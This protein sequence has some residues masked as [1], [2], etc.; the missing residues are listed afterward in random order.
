MKRPRVLLVDEAPGTHRS[1]AALLSRGGYEVATASDGKEA[2]EKAG[3][4]RPDLILLDFPPH[5]GRDFRV[6]RQ[7]SEHVDTR[8][9]PIV[10]ITYMEQTPPPIRQGPTDP[11]RRFIYRPCR[12]KTLLEGIGDVL[13]RGY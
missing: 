13:R 7:L 10:M 1:T 5:R 9:I 8:A 2:L 4:T 3:E 12:P 6:A 11:I